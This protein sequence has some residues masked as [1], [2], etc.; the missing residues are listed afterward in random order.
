MQVQRQL[1]TLPETDLP[2]LLDKLVACMR[3]AAQGFPAA[4]TP[5]AVALSALVV[6]WQDWDGGP[7]TLG[8][9]SPLM[10]PLLT[11]FLDC[12]MSFAVLE[13]RSGDVTC[14]GVEGC[15]VWEQGLPC[16]QCPCCRS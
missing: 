3:G 7:Q 15:W 2:A 11:T 13:R 1:R 6:Q 8:R 10:P 5:L 14:L 9:R 12:S 4:V 16:P